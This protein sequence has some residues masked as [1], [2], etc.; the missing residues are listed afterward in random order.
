M[1]ML[2]LSFWIKFLDGDLH[3]TIEHLVLKSIPKPILSS[4][5]TIYNALP[6]SISAEHIVL[7]V[8]VF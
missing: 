4:S 7:T 5:K 2:L 8:T 1:F 6:F 3:Q